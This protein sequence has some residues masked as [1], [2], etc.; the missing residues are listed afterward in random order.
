MKIA[1]AKNNLAKSAP[2]GGAVSR[3]VVGG[4]RNHSQ[5]QRAPIGR[6]SPGRKALFSS[7]HPAP[8]SWTASA[9]F[10]LIEVLLA[11]AVCAVV[12]VVISTVFAGALKLQESA[13]ATVDEKLPIERAMGQ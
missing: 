2:M 9:G 4:H 1:I 11:L 6:R 8:A 3:I 5:N 10:T 12:L 7:I 13:A